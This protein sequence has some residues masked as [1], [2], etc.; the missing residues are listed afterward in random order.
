VLGA[1]A[2]A[3]LG[4]AVLAHVAVVAAARATHYVAIAVR[5]A[6]IGARHE[7]AVAAGVLR[8]ALALA[9]REALAA[10]G[11]LVRARH[12]AAVRAG[13]PG[14]AHACLAAPG[15]GHAAAVEGAR[16]IVAAAARQELGARRTGVADKT[17]APPSHA[18]AVARAFG[19]AVA[20]VDGSRR[21]DCELRRLGVRRAPR[22]C[23]RVGRLGGC[24][25][26]GR[27]QEHAS[28]Q[29]RRVPSQ[30]RTRHAQQA[31]DGGTRK[32]S[33]PRKARGAKI[34]RAPHVLEE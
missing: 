21:R 32:M 13:E 29:S 6:L 26:E 33:A 7:R 14:V 23:C 27:E 28:S 18:C 16:V 24:W 5:R 34:S 3:R 19:R 8:V 2:G 1:A 31:D 30:G 4:R 9:R 25:R 11:A 20:L 22:G 10:S 17:D 12:H 15:T